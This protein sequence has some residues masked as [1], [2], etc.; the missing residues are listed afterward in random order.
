VCLRR[1]RAKSRHAVGEVLTTVGHVAFDRAIIMARSWGAA[2]PWKHGRRGGTARSPAAA[3]RMLTLAGHEWS[4][5]G[6]RTTQ[7]VLITWWSPTTHRDVSAR[8]RA[9]KPDGGLSE[10]Q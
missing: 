8:R 6:H 9:T 1:G 10:S 7:G 3:R 5:V 2:D 4:F